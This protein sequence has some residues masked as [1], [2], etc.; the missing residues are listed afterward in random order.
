MDEMIRGMAIPE[1]L[2]QGQ[3]FVGKLK[4]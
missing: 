4:G 1:G 3:M 2:Q